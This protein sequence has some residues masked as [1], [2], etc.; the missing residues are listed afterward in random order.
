M[1]HVITQFPIV[2][3]S[4]HFVHI[5]SM[6]SPF[7][8]GKFCKIF[9]VVVALK[10]QIHSLVLYAVSFHI[11]VLYTSSPVILRFDLK[12]IATKGILSVT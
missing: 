1:L 7:Q 2:V 5:C 4:I 6:L 8:I 11:C 12:L 10:W 9:N 3:D